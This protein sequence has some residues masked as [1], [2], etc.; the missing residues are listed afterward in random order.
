MTPLTYT[1]EQAAEVLQI[2]R[3]AAYEA[4][5]RGEI[6]SIRIGRSLRVPRQRLLAL[7]DPENDDGPA[8]NGAVTKTGAGTPDGSTV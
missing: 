1:V 4:V 5:R 7:L 2:G 3:T 8:A 6:P